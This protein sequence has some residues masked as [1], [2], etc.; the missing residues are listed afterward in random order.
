MKNK[1]YKELK[2]YEDILH[3]PHYVSSRRSKMAISDRAAQFSPFAAVVGHETAVKEAA[4][5]TEIRK[6]LDE[7]EKALIDEQLRDIEA[8]LPTEFDVEVVYFKPDELK[9]GGEYITIVGQIKKFDIYEKEVIMVD[10]T[11]I[12]IEDIYSINQL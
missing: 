10:E 3:L 4:R 11:R 8:K 5:N 2:N 1:I 6:E 12:G 9:A 7:M